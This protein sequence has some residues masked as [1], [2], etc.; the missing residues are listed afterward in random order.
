MIVHAGLKHEYIYSFE[1]SCRLCGKDRM[2]VNLLN[3]LYLVIY[4]SAAVPYLFSLLHRHCDR[5]PRLL[6]DFGTDSPII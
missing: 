4:V 5:I 2:H 1:R 3:N 6:A